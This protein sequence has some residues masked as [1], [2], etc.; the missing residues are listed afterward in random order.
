MAFSVSRPYSSVDYPEGNSTVERFHG[1]LKSRLDKL[2][3]EG[4]DFDTATRT[5]YVSCYTYSKLYVSCYTCQTSQWVLPHLRK[6]SVD[7][8]PRGE[9][10]WG[11]GLSSNR[12][13]LS[14]VYGRRNQHS[15]CITK[16]FR[17]GEVLLRRGRANKFVI[18]A[19]IVR[20][21][22]IVR[23]WLIKMESYKSTIKN[24]SNLL[25]CYHLKNLMLLKRKT[26]KI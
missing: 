10:L 15:R 5:L 6:I 19:S 21:K 3:H 24:S 1:T 23:G 12:F 22:V 20:S 4:V 25:R 17:E 13:K 7:Q 26:S 14:E 9:V 16:I 8:W 18:P 11:K 2:F